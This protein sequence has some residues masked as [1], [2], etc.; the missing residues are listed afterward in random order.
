[1]NKNICLKGYDRCD[2]EFN[3]RNIYGVYLKYPQNRDMIEKS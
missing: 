3:Q 2:C 1:M